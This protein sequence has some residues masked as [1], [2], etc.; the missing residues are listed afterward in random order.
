[1]ELTDYLIPRMGRATRDR[2]AATVWGDNDMLPELLTL[3]Q[4]GSKIQ[5]MKGAWVLSGIHAIDSEFLNSHQPFLL[6][7]LRCETIGGVKRELL[8][9]FEGIVLRDEIS[10][11]IISITMA[12]VTDDKQ[13]LAVRYLC[14]RLLVP[15][16]R[17][18][19]ELQQ[20]LKD[21]TE[22]YRSK[23]GRFP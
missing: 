22:L 7:L 13:D 12:W 6:Q 14:Y 21:Q 23:F 19:P 11:Q 20:E 5:R 9:C 18:Y 4:S 17:P 2:L 1:M 15:L 16:L 3:I 8:R 10:E